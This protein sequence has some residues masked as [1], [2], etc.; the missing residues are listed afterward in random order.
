M[1]LFER[2]FGKPKDVQPSGYFLTLNGYSP[3]FTS[4]PESVYEMAV[5]RAAIHSFAT[6]CSKLKPEVTG[7]AA[8]HLKNTLAF[9]PNPFQDTAKFLYRI[10]TILNVHNTTFIVPISIR[11]RGRRLVFIRFYRSTRNSSTFAGRH[12]SVIGSRTGNGRRSSWIGSGY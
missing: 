4:A 2:I 1:G 7:S 3:V 9:R 5:T 6:F 10:A 11:S 8:A 12:S